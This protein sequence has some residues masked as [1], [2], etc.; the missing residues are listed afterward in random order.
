VTTVRTKVATAPPKNPGPEARGSQPKGCESHGRSGVGPVA[1]RAG[2][3]EV[4]VVEI[5]DQLGPALLR[6]T[7]GPSVVIH[8]GGSSALA[9]E[10]RALLVSA[11]VSSDSVDGDAAAVGGAPTLGVAVSDHVHDPV[12]AGAWLRRDVPH[13]HVVIGDRSTRIGPVVLP[14]S[15]ACAHCLDLHR[16]DVD[17]A[18]GV[19]A[20]QLWG[21]PRV[22]PSLLATREAAVFAARRA[23]ARAS[24]DPAR[25]PDATIETIDA[26]S[27]AVTRSTSRPHPRCGCAV[28]PRSDSAGDPS[29]LGPAP[30][31]SRRGEAVAVPA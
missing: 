6:P 19:I 10:I 14:G 17:A 20:G 29:A 3:R 21:R 12:L 11:G 25:L 27:G 28:L 16:A 1:Q 4:D 30:D 18:W 8:V 24:G 5:V 15:T 9:D 2:C 23:L 31:D 26:E 13:L 7:P 22:S